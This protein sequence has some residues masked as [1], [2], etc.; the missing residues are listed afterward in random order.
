[1]SFGCNPTFQVTASQIFRIS[2][3]IDFGLRLDTGGKAQKYAIEDGSMM[4][5]IEIFTQ[6]C[7][8]SIL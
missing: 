4:V 8:Y 6:V 1:M 3:K 2:Q 7:D 5:L